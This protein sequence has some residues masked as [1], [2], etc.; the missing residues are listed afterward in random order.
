MPLPGFDVNDVEVTA[1]PNEVIVHAATEKESKAEQDNVLWTEFGSNDFYRRFDVPN[2]VNVDQV[3][4]KLDN[5]ILKVNAPK[6]G[7]PKEVK[8][9][10]A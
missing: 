3:T 4:A 1:T 8:I 10:T 5:G 7:K 9:A 6:I 2:A